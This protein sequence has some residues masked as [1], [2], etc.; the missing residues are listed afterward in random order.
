MRL[1]P[2]PELVVSRWLNSAE[3][4]SLANLRGRVVVLYA[5]QMLCPGCVSTALP[6]AQRVFETFSGGDV[7]VLGL[8]T[9]F[10]HHEANSQAAL[11]AFL[12]EY[13][14]RFPV[15]VDAPA[16]EGAIPQSM[17]AYGL[18]GTPSLILIDR[19]GQVR[20]HKFGHET[21]LKLGAEIMAVV[22]QGRE[23][24]GGGPTP[25]S[26]TAAVCDADACPA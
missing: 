25:R 7:A 5:F 17:R 1:R 20:K 15:G 12:H 22:R 19:D 23:A 14:I 21:D 11:E 6:Q 2:A 24:E 18:Q 16:P 9:V 3:P 26:S 8:H 10:E 13:R 4:I